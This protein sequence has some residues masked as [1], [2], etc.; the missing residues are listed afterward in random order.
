MLGIDGGGSKTLLALAEPAAASRQPSRGAGINPMDRPSWR[1]ALA[2]L[3]GRVAGPAAHRRRRRGLPA[4]G[5]LA[6]V[7]A[8]QEAAYRGSS[9]PCRGA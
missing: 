1:E 8:A 7:E 9:A 2:T 6:A 5:E 4:H 3:V